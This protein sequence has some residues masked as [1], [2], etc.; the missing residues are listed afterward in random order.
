[1]KPGQNGRSAPPAEAPKKPVRRYLK[2]AEIVEEFRV[3]LDTIYQW[4]RDKHLAALKVGGQWRIREEDWEDFLERC[5]PEGIPEPPKETRVQAA[6]RRR[7]DEE[8]GRMVRQ[9]LG[10]PEPN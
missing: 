8:I 6:R 7:E 1:M 10:L 4:I 5:N 9:R 2:P 3:D